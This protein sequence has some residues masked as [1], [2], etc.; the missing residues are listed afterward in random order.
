ML[1]VLPGD[2]EPPLLGEKVTS[3]GAVIVQLPLGSLVWF[4]MVSVA[5][6]P[7]VTFKVLSE[8]LSD[9]SS[10]VTS[11]PSPPPVQALSPPLA[12]AR[13]AETRVRNARRWASCRFETTVGGRYLLTK[14]AKPQSGYGRTDLNR[15]IMP[16]HC[17]PSVTNRIVDKLPQRWRSGTKK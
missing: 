3:A 17:R 7:T 16:P 12:T 4:V 2:T 5:S 15:Q 1:T 9:P 13:I 11:T 10:T 6:R 14:S 8:R